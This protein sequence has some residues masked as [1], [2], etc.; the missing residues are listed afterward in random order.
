M[1]YFGSGGTASDAV[2]AMLLWLPLSVL[3][4]FVIGWL[5]SRSR[6]VWPPAILHGGSN[7]VVAVGLEAFRRLGWSRECRYPPDVR[8]VRTGRSLHRGSVDHA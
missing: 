1:G 7:L 6:S 3:L 4:E 5:W 8:C 2:V